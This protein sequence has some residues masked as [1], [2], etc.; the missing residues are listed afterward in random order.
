MTSSHSYLTYFLDIFEGRE[1][2][3]PTPRSFT[4]PPK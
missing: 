4:L 1:K 2:P 3:S